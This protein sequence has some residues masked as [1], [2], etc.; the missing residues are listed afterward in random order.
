MTTAS[1]SRDCVAKA[2]G[3]PMSEVQK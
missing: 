2:L 1:R 3:I